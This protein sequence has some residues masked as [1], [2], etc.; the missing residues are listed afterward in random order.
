MN[1]QP[2]TFFL[3]TQG[4]KILPLFIPLSLPAHIDGLDDRF[5]QIHPLTMESDPSPSSLR[6]ETED[7]MPTRSMPNRLHHTL[8]LLYQCDETMTEML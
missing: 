2:H 8:E 3:P 4:E 7:L 6:V 1:K 5:H